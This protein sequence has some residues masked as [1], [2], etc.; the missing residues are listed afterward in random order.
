M[1]QLDILV[2][3]TIDSGVTPI[4]MRFTPIYDC[5]FSGTVGFRGK[6]LVNSILYGV[7]SPADYGAALEQDRDLAGAFVSR[8]LRSVLS[9]LARL[10]AETYDIPFVSLQCPAMLSAKGVFPAELV[11]VLRGTEPRYAAAICFEFGPE[12]YSLPEKILLD[13]LLYIR[14]FGCRIAVSGYGAADFPMTALPSAVP[15]LLVLSAPAAWDVARLSAY[16]GFARSLG[17]RVL[18]EDVAG[19]G[20]LKQLQAAQ[21]DYYTPASGLRVNGQ[22][23][24]RQRELEPL[25]SERG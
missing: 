5:L 4:D 17:V 13:L 1:D 11:R 18:A 9:T 22:S 25:L 14:S 2:T 20:R 23:M 3:R 15:D 8:N 24:Y 6:A 16:I 10:C 12:L 19:E 21:C 7:L